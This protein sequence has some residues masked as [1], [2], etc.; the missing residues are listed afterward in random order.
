ML[1]RKLHGPAVK[2]IREA[3]GIKHGIFAIQCG[4][5]PGYLSNIER[6]HKQPSPTVARAIVDRLGVGMD[7]VTYVITPEDA[8][9]ALA[10][11]E[12]A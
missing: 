5:T 7:A 10:G 1:T 11:R 8:R 9:A 2:A 4:I 12:S 3:L 6:G